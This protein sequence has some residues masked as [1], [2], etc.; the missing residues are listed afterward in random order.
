M[1]KQIYIIDG[2]HYT[3]LRKFL[4]NGTEFAVLCR[5]GGYDEDME[6]KTTASLVKWEDSYNYRQEQ[7][8][9]AKLATIKKEEE[10]IIKGF[11]VKALKSITFR[12]KMNMVFTKD[13][14]ISLVGMTVVDELEKII[15]DY[16]MAD[17][18]KIV[19]ENG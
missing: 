15:N 19:E 11:Q 2:G 9:V 17:A 12:M 5:E 14:K 7:E 3:I 1:K 18:K 16:G 8:R 10:T 13:G 6:I 4:K